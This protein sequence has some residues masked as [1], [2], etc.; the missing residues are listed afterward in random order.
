MPRT[1][2]QR[3]KRLRSS[4][5]GGDAWL[6]RKHARDLAQ[7]SG[8]EMSCL[9]ESWASLER[10][11]K[12]AMYVHMYVC[13]GCTMIHMSACI[14]GFLR[15]QGSLYYSLSLFRRYSKYVYM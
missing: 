11:E 12:D 14:H 6:A 10:G 8:E 5:A 7:R 13:T 1:W 2:R 4:G 9:A 3:D 15:T